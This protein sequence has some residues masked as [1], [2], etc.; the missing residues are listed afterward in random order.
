MKEKILNN[1]KCLTCGEKLI[2]L[3]R[4]NSSITIKV[5]I[6]KKCSFFIDLNK[7][8]NWTL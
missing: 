6:N 3:K 2:K 8:K 1:I 7:L 5:C 4:K